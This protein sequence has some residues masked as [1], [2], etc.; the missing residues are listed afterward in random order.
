MSYWLTEKIKSPT[1][2]V[3][4]LQI[5]T[6][7]WQTIHT[8]RTWKEPI[9]EMQFTDCFCCYFF[10][11]YLDC[12]N[13]ISTVA[14][15]SRLCVREHI[16][17]YATTGMWWG[18]YEQSASKS[19]HFEGGAPSAVNIWPTA[20]RKFR[21]CRRCFEDEVSEIWTLYLRECRTAFVGRVDLQQTED[22][23]NSWRPFTEKRRKNEMEV[24]GI[25]RVGRSFGVFLLATGFYRQLSACHFNSWSSSFILD[26]F[27]QESILT[28]AFF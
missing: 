4:I 9:R 18:Y 13:C 7:K 15:H 25:A 23:T 3:Q 19:N 12:N 10:C 24:E 27:G 21:A 14:Q 5:Y 1:S 28:T 11:F 22:R 6:Q 2:E 8:L 16:Y 17:Y 26:S 20:V